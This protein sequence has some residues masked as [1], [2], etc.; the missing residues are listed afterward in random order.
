MQ[1]LEG[2]SAK[3]Y[4]L[5]TTIRELIHFSYSFALKQTK[6]AIKYEDIWHYIEEGNRFN[7]GE[8]ARVLLSE[9]CSW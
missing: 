6:P 3:M 2:I 7:E 9:S 8:T 5:I 1:P 4:A